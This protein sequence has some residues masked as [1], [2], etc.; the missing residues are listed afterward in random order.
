MT[1]AEGILELA[2]GGLAFVVFFVV[3]LA[4]WYQ[5]GA[6]RAGFVLMVAIWFLALVAVLALATVL[7]VPVHGL[8]VICINGC[9]MAFY[10]HLYT[11]MLRSV[12]LR[13]LGELLKHDGRLTPDALAAAYSP[14]SMLDSRLAWLVERGW[15]T[16]MDGVYHLTTAGRRLLAWRRPLAALMIQG[17]T[18]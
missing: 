13:L 18:G 4:V 5:R 3:H 1:V 14:E 8:T 15:L 12:S 11:G 16:E 7:A 17:P 2:F 9:L 10:M 6:E